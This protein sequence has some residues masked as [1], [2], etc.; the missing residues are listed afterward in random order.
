LR[1]DFDRRRADLKGIA[2]ANGLLPGAG[3]LTD[4]ARTFS[5]PGA[6]PGISAGGTNRG[7]VWALNMGTA[8]LL[9]ACNATNFTTE[10]LQRRPGGGEPRPSPQRHQICRAGGRRRAGS[11]TPP[12]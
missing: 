6:T 2:P 12:A 8:Q 9:L 10:L 3:V 11:P 5:F 1:S 7:I 4:T